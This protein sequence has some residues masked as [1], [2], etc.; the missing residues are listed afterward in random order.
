MSLCHSLFYCSANSSIIFLV[1]SLILYLWS[2]LSLLQAFHCCTAQRQ[3]S[4]KYGV[5]RQLL[6]S[7]EN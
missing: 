5:V 4:L 2:S 7:L 6:L 1:L 3:P